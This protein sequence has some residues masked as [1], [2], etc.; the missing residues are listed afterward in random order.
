MTSSI[1]SRLAFVVLVCLV[2][3]APLAS[4]AVTCGQVSE[5]VRPCTIYLRNGGTVPAPCCNGVR[6]LSNWAKT[7]IDRQS[8]CRCLVAAARSNCGLKLNLVA[9]LPIRCGVRLP[10]TISPDTNCDEVH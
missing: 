9:G 6:Y 10:Y 8:V 4:H 1:A 2:V 5:S 3:G 7:T